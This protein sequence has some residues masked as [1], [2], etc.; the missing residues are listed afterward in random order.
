MIRAS[1][2]LEAAISSGS[3]PVIKYLMEYLLEADPSPYI[4]ESGSTKLASLLCRNN[5]LSNIKFIEFLIAKGADPNA[6]DEREGH[7]LLH[8]VIRLAFPLLHHAAVLARLHE[9]PS[10]PTTLKFVRKLIEYGASPNTIDKFGK[11][12]W[13]YARRMYEEEEKSFVRCFIE[14]GVDITD[15]FRQ[16]YPSTASILRDPTVQAKRAIAEQFKG[17]LLAHRA[18]NHETH[19]NFEQYYEEWKKFAQKGLSEEEKRLFNTD[20]GKLEL[21]KKHCKIVY[22]AVYTTKGSENVD[23][24]L[25]FSLVCHKRVGKNAAV[26]GLVPDLIHVTRNHLLSPEHPEVLARHSAIMSCLNNTQPLSLDAA[27]DHNNSH[28]SNH[29]RP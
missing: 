6:L 16:K 19:L 2:V 27:E 25:F 18:I 13:A 17:N 22:L 3:V 1:I 9:I 24:T 29:R 4:D 5:G 21:F 7:A 28:R 10:I 26:R 8:R 14:H 23:K 11:A 20:T 15:A 12:P